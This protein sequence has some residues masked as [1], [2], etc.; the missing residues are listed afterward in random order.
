[1]HQKTMKDYITGVK[2][3]SSRNAIIK[4]KRVKR[5][6]IRKPQLSE[7]KH[8]LNQKLCDLYRE[9]KSFGNAHIPSISRKNTRKFL[10]EKTLDL[11]GYTR[12]KAIESLYVF[13]E[14][15]QREYIRNVLVITGGSSA[16]QSVIRSLFKQWMQEYFSNYVSAYG[17]ASASDGGEGAFYVVLK[18]TYLNV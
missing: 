9:D 4:C 3:L 1:M 17:H 13:F 16:R 5:E 18:S 15:C 7:I 11:H 2:P 10:A 6:L 12:E 14:R 8:S